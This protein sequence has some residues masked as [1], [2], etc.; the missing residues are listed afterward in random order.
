MDAKAGFAIKKL[1]ESNYN[2][3]KTDI[4]DVLLRE[5]LWFVVCEEDKEPAE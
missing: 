1:G 4:V 3:W 5:D 2:I